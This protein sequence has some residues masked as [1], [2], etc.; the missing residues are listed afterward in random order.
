MPSKNRGAIVAFEEGETNIYGLHNAQERGTLF[1]GPQVKVYK[2]MIVGESART[3]DIHINVCKKKHVTNMR[4][5]I[6]DEALK[7]TP[8]K[9]MTLEK[10][11]EFIDEDEVVEITP[12]NIRVRKSVISQ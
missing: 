10:Y 4:S 2:G 3:E 8:P 9:E 7:L 1:I 5:V 11:L 6:A 12:K